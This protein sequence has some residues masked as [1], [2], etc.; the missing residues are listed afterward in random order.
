MGKQQRT[1]EETAVVERAFQSLAAGTLGNVT[2]G[3]DQAL[4]VR[5][6]RGSHLWDFSGNEY[7][8]YL[9]GSGPMVIGHAH[10]DVT[11]AVAA[12]LDKGS[13]YFLTNLP[14]IELA[15]EIIRAVPCAEKV[16]FTT[17][18]TDATFQCLRLARAYRKRD[19]VL[20]FEGGFHG[21]HDYSLMSLAPRAGQLGEFPAPAS[22]SGGIPRAVQETVLVAPYNDLQYTAD[23]LAKR[24]DEIGAVIIEP[25]QRVLTPVPGF[26][27]GLRELCTRYEIPLIFDEVVTGFRVAYGGAQEYYDVQPDLCALG[28]V[29]GGGFALAAVCGRADI[30]DYY[31]PAAIASN[32]FVP[33]IGTLS[34]NPI[35][36]VAGLATLQVLRQPGQYEKLFANGRRLMAAVHETL[37][38]HEIPHQISGEP[39]CFDVYFSPT[40]VTN[41]REHLAADGA[42]AARLCAALMRRNILK[43]GQKFYLSLAHTNEDLAAT[44]QAL[45][46][47]VAEI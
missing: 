36:S 32:D 4:V 2:F 21:M 18:G 6:A 44:E 19:L 38:Q 31:D 26:L 8:D 42:R 47:A 34:G 43:P 9:L 24:H 10:P 20:K 29:V 3:K 23:L 12:A 14:A 11:E 28:K 16:R 33:M 40:P 37:G 39:P 5:E 27:Q 22:G 45:R 15:E 17:S 30:M 1:A 46:E 13:T 25:M 35:A 41:Y 7:I